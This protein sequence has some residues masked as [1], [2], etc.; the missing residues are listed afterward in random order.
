MI[1]LYVKHIHFMVKIYYTSCVCT[2]TH[3][4]FNYIIWWCDVC[5][6]SS[7]SLVIL[8]QHLFSRLNSTIIALLNTSMS[9]SID[10]TPFFV[11]FRQWKIPYLALNEFDWSIKCTDTKMS[12]WNVRKWLEKHVQQI[13]SLNGKRALRLG[14]LEK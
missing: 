8:W 14:S 11:L 4:T 10:T 6:F 5:F 9:I 2:L 1:Y 13:W 3:I 7:L 12:H